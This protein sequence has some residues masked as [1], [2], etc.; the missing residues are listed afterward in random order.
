MSFVPWSV[1][2][3]GAIAVLLLAL[4]FLAIW[5]FKEHSPLSGHFATSHGAVGQIG[6]AKIELSPDHKRGEL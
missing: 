2:M 5:I 4:L 1:W 3:A 6:P